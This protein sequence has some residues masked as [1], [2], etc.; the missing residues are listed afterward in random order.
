M[1]NA[2]D[3]RHF[4]SF[5]QTFRKYLLGVYIPVQYTYDIK[6]KD[7]FALKKS[8]KNQRIKLIV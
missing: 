2:E 7:G 4:F 1:K 3:N 6:M 8:C 5:H